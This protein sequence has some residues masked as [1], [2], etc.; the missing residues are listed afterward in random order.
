MKTCTILVLFARIIGWCPNASFG[1]K[2]DAEDSVCGDLWW[3]E[4]LLAMIFAFGWKDGCQLHMC[5][6]A[7]GSDQRTNVPHRVGKKK[8]EVLAPHTIKSYNAYM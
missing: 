4:N 1:Q 3:A 8:T 7:D 5:L 6:T 2:K